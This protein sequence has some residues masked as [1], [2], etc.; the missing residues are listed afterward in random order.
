MKSEPTARQKLE[1][2]LDEIASLHPNDYRSELDAVIVEA[3]PE[4]SAKPI[5]M[6]EFGSAL[7]SLGSSITHTPPEPTDA[8][9][10]RAENMDGHFSNTHSGGNRK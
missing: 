5:P 2:Y 1:H 3:A 8:E 10:E 7:G 9:V 6:S 4:N